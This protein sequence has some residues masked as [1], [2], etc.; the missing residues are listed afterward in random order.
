MVLFIRSCFLHALFYGVASRGFGFSVMRE[1]YDNRVSNAV[2]KLELTFTVV[3]GSLEICEG[4][5]NA[6]LDHRISDGEESVARK[7]ECVT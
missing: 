4:N 6:N 7:A 2:K 3:T 1:V 5:G